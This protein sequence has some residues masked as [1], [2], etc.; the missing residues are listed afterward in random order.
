MRRG[1]TRVGAPALAAALAA[2]SLS[3]ATVKI[4]VCDTVGGLLARARPAASRSPPTGRSWRAGTLA[5]VDGVSEAVLFAAAA[6]K[7][8]ELYVG[9]GDSGQDPA[10]VLGGHGRDLG[11]AA[12]SRRS[13]RSRS[14]RTARVY[15]G[16]SPGGKVYRIENGKAARLLRDEGPV[17]LG[18]GV[19]GP[20]A[21]RRDRAS[22]RDP[23]RSARRARASAFTRRPTRTC[24]RSTP[25]PKG[26]VWAGTSGSGLVLRIDKTGRVS[27]LYDSAKPEITAITGGRRAAASGRPP[28]PRTWRPAS[29]EP[30]SVP[31][32][33]D[34]REARARR[35]TRGTRRTAV[36]ARSHGQRL[37]AAPGPVPRASGGAATPR[38]SSCSRRAS[39]RARSGRARD[40]VVFDLAPE[41]T[42]APESWRRRVP[43]GKLYAHRA[44]RR[45]RSCGPST[46]SRSRSWRETTSGP[47]PRRALYR[48]EPGS[49]VGRVRLRRSRTRAAPAGS[50]R[51]AGKGTR[52][53]ARKL[54]FAF[55]SGESATPDST[56][57]DWTRVGAGGAVRDDRGARRPLPPVEGPDGARTASGRRGS[58]ARRRPTAT[59]TPRPSIES[60]R[61]SSRPR[62]SRGRARAGS[63]VFETRG[64]RRE[65]DLH[66]PRGVEVRG[67]AAQALPQGLPDAP[68]EG[69]RSRRRHAD[70]RDRRSGRPAGSKWIVLRKDVRESF[71]SF[72]TTSLP[73]GEY[74]FRVTASDAESNPADAK[75][76]VP[77]VLARASSTTRPR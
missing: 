17:R 74:V 61:R 57:S 62:S 53:R 33:A 71:Y 55:R 60:L 11:D 32:V 22:G 37:D 28:A 46:R 66:E 34:G 26:R 44:R 67:L 1:L 63:N 49:S 10:R 13:P 59:A 30:I 69:D 19:L 16:G 14:V 65:G 39:R 51:F 38:R 42:P 47:T 77:R 4:W 70:L 15:A 54:E 2:A 29:A 50:A 5:K 41:T 73:D 72:D 12:R 25:T 75:T 76:D 45:R 43:R 23:P 9:T 8:G 58:G 31:V 6:G 64:A 52:P 21:V 27:T 20:R 40:E 56:W 68:V 7:G 3:A 48:G 18:A 36:E 35:L 24:A